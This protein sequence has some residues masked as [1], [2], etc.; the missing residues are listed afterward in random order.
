MSNLPPEPG[1]V[2]DPNLGVPDEDVVFGDNSQTFDPE[3][4]DEEE[5]EDD[6]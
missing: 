1:T 5:E 6:D 2:P 4:N 3:V